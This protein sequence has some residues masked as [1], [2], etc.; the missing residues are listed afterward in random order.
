MRFAE[1]AKLGKYVKLF[2]K[3]AGFKFNTIK[4]QKQIVREKLFFC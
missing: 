3:S 4:S 1:I 2:D